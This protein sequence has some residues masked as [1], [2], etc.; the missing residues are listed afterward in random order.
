MNPDRDARLVSA[1]VDGELDAV[2]AMEFEARLAADP[3]IRAAFEDL[4]R[5]RT[6]IRTDASYHTAPERLRS[7]IASAGARHDSTAMRERVIRWWPAAAGFAAG[8]IATCIV[9]LLPP[10][11]AREDP[12]LRDVVASHVRATLDQ[13]LVDVASSDQHTVK[14]WL[15]ARL[16]FSPPV[17][18]FAANGFELAG[19]RLDYVAGRPVA[20]LVYRHRQHVIDVFIWP[21]TPDRPLRSFV[22]QGFNVANFARGGMTFW[23]VSDVAQADL[24][25]FAQGLA[26]APRE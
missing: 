11:V 14:P 25:A 1:Y 20:D 24:E 22:L 4:K 26:Q 21:A 6:Q 9:F 12:L 7:R 17:R 2:A 15:S 5:L 23:V 16:D 10:L 18:D 3:K 8:V 13:R 19:G